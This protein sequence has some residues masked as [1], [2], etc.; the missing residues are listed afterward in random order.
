MKS[1]I[2]LVLTAVF[3]LGLAVAVYAFNKTSSSVKASA[4]CCAKSDACPLK[5]KA[6]QTTAENHSTASCCDRA[7]YC[8]KTDACPMKASDGEKGA[9]GCCD[10]CCGGSCPMKNK[11]E[12]AFNQ[13]AG[14]SCQHKTAGS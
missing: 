7:D 4:S 2:L 14:E 6:A 1:K 9:A 5:N 12:T 13:T 3:V 11:N 10:S 8:C